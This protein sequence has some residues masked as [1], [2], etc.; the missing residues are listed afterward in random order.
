MNRRHKG[1]AIGLLAPLLLAASLSAC[2]SDDSDSAEPTAELPEA[3]SS[4]EGEITLGAVLPLTGNSASIGQDQQ[5]GI[6]LAVAEINAGDGVLGKKLVVASEDSEGRADAAI[7]AAQKLV[8]VDKVPAVIGEYSSGN[9]I[10]MQQFLAEQGVVGVNP[11]SS[12]ADVRNTGDLQFSVIGDELKAGVF[13]AEHLYEEGHRSISILAPNNAYGTGV[14]EAVGDS[15]EELGGTVNDTVIFNEGQADYRQELSRL[16]D[17]A[18]D[19]YVVTM[20]SQD[21][22]VINREMFEAGMTDSSIFAIY[23]SMTTADSDPTAVEGHE[24]MDVLTS[25]AGHDDYADQ[26]ESI[27]GESF[28][29]SFNG[30]AYDAVKMLAEAINTAGSEDPQAIADALMEISQG[31]EGVTGPIEFDA[32][33]QRSQQ[34]YMVGVIEDGAIVP[35]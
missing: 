17:S 6:E 20:Y 21:G 35:Q 16:E 31:Y 34:D 29:S 18:P 25:E 8:N 3:N 12:S 4:L 7:Q 23:L 1:R 15:F 9:T 22:A 19:A 26:Y 13:T 27:F 33:G 28:S 2:G 24:G 5:R 32:D 30:Y 10:P 11:G 14:S